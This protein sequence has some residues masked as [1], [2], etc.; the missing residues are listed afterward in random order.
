TYDRRFK[1]AEQTNGEDTADFFQRNRSN[2][3]NLRTGIKIST[4]TREASN[5]KSDKICVI[6]GNLRQ[7]V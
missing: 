2:L 6:S 3:R 1:K 7:A 5:R 4:V